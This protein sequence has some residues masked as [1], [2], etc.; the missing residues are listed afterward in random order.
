MK[1]ALLLGLLPLAALADPVQTYTLP[2]DLHLQWPS[3]LVSLPAPKLRTEPGD[4]FTLTVE[5]H[6][7]PVQVG[8]A[9][10]GSDAIWS[11]VTAVEKTDKDAKGRARMPAD[12]VAE[13]NL[14]PQ[15][16]LPADA[17]LHVDD[18]KDFFTVSNGRYEFRLRKYAGRLANPVE[19]KDLP[20]WIGGMRP[21]GTETWDGVAAFDGSARVVAA[22]TE[23]LASGP[24][25]AE[26]RVRLVFEGAE[27]PDGTVPALPLANGKQTHFWKPAEIPLQDLP[28][29]EKAYEAR[30]RFVW[31]DPWIDVAELYRLPPCPGANSFNIHQYTLAWGAPAKGGAKASFT[32]VDTVTWVRWFE[33]DAFGGNIDQKWVPAEPRPAQKGRPFALLR[34]AWNQGGAGAQDFFLTRGGTNG[35][36]N[37]D[38]PMF[39]VV[40]AYASKWINPYAQ[41][42]TAY[43][44]D[45]T[46][47]SCRFPLVDGGSAGWYAQRAYG[48]CCGP[49]GRFPTLN[50]L[51]RRHTDWTLDA[52]A[53]RYVLRWDGRA[54]KP[55]AKAPTCQ[56]YLER[57]YQDDFLNP[58]QRMTRNLKQF[59]SV[60]PG[61]CGADHAAMGYIFTDPDHWPGW[62]SGWRPGNPNFNTDKYMGTIYIASAMPEHPDAKNWL[63]HGLRNYHDDLARVFHGPDRVGVECPGYSGY[64]MGLQLEIAK[65]LLQQG[66]PADEVVDPAFTASTRWHRKL[67]TPLDPRLGFRHEAPIGDTHRWTSGANVSFGRLAL[68]LKTSDRAAASEFRAVGEELA[69]TGGLKREDWDKLLDEGLRDV[70]AAKFNG[71]DWSSQ[72][73]EGFGAVLRDA[74]GTPSE[75]FVSIKAGS[76]GGHY[77]NDDLSFHSYL[78][79]CPAA[80]DYNCSYHPRG[81]HAALHNALTFGKEGTT[82]HHARGEKVET[83]EQPT[84]RASATS[85]HAGPRADVFT[86]ERTV[87]S[88][89]FMPVFPDDSEYNRDYPSRSVDPIAQTRTVAL[90]KPK[91]GSKMPGYLVVRD[92][93][94]GAEPVQLNLHLLARS[95]EGDGPVFRA[96]GQWNRD[97]SVF[98]AHAR[99]E[100][101]DKREW[102]YY[103]EWMVGPMEWALQP[104]EPQDAWAKRVGTSLPPKDWKPQYRERNAPAGGW[105][106]LIHDTH[107]GALMPPK[108]W[109]GPWQYGEVQQWLRLHFPAKTDVIWVLFANDPRETPPEFAEIPNGVRVTYR[110]ETNTVRFADNG[111]VTVE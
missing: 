88:L 13:L 27:T 45:G 11:V 6:E 103:D 91:K 82:D 14:R 68:L 49:R 78:D 17:C 92:Q 24:V 93:V 28:K 48:L 71:L 7:R 40:A 79:G 30:V 72:A 23:M 20:H 52:Q 105:P 86:A 94:D 59:A 21:A 73:F 75:S 87:K 9:P 37:A 42:I 98:I 102:H 106:K 77:H 29:F 83:H 66:V 36:D 10:D 97:F 74:F 70:P 18:G 50:N 58:T 19:L 12:I 55:S 38:A 57:R 34:P 64:S 109:S 61:T 44:N 53:N 15:G 22:E 100:K 32:P 90:V 35:A 56:L 43:A 84:A 54:E 63:R 46:R 80:L 85:F 81:D 65:N 96:P 39:G 99:P 2:N 25:F 41:T 110:G 62:N 8:K 1:R 107:G 51:V 5:G 60:K 104:G 31:D 3:D 33:W 95:I 101:T 67:L 76:L 47:G 111:T 108:G 26:F 69:R 89:A 4:V 16:S